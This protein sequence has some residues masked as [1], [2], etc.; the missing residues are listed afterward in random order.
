MTTGTAERSKDAL[1]RIRRELV[2]AAARRNKRRRRRRLLAVAALPIVTLVAGAGA[3]AIVQFSTGVP[4]IDR[5]LANETPGPGTIDLRPGPGGASEPLPL[6]N[7]PDGRDAAAVAYVSRDGHVCIA[8]G[9]V[10]RRDNAARGSSG[11]SCY[12][13]AELARMLSTGTVVCCALAASPERRVYDGFA[14]GNV[15]ALR[16]QVEGSPP[17]EARLTPPWTPDAPGAEPLRLFVA[18][19]ETD[20]GV[21][22]DG[23]Q[24][25][26]GSRLIDERYRV[27]A[28]L[29]DGRTIQ[30]RTPWTRQG[31]AP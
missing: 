20:I 10:R 4:A 27:E 21:G 31:T 17:F 13:P 6:P 22:G 24:F 1:D 9:D 15:A 16:F 18:I 23:V 7:S 29:E 19:N 25:N 5:L 2:A 11:G 3:V 26:E 28:R 30:V 12:P 8:R 14:A